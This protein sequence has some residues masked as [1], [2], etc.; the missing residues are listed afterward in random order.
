MIDCKH[1]APQ[2]IHFSTSVVLKVRKNANN[3]QNKNNKSSFKTDSFMPHFPH[4]LKPTKGKLCRNILYSFTKNM[5]LLCTLHL[6]W[7]DILLKSSVP[8]CLSSIQFYPST[9]ISPAIL[10]FF[11]EDQLYSKANLFCNLFKWAKNQLKK[12]KGFSFNQR[13]IIIRHAKNNINL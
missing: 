10:S 5:Q 13:S 4:S 8:T 2:F 12:V 1:F 9:T 6:T 3:D 11:L 7:L